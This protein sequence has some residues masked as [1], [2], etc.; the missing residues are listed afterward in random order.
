MRFDERLKT[1]TR[2][3]LAFSFLAKEKR[4][5]Y[6]H[7][8]PYEGIWAYNKK[9]KRV[10]YQY[11][12]FQFKK[13]MH[14]YYSGK[15]GSEEFSIIP[16]PKAFYE[17][18]SSNPKKAILENKKEV[19]SA[20][21]WWGKFADKLG[22]DKIKSDEYFARR[23]LAGYDEKKSKRISDFYAK[24]SGKIIDSSLIKN[25]DISASHPLYLFLK[26]K[27]INLRWKLK[28]A[29]LDGNNEAFAKALKFN[30]EQT[31]GL[32]KINFNNLLDSAYADRNQKNALYIISKCDPK[33]LNDDF[34]FL[35]KIISP[36]EANMIKIEEF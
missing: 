21:Y 7:G 26:S 5:T 4:I 36:C 23:V 29:L 14:Y 13:E 30:K 34:A 32:C 12:H 28:Q 10:R 11:A 17:F 2:E 19:T 25:R 35:N 15:R 22:I 20:I 31:K 16:M 24:N 33:I 8:G 3:G 6:V 1:L 18:W 9:T 27:K